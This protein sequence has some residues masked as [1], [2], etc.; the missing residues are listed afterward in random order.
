[1]DIADFCQE[2]S[3]SDGACLFE[4]SDSER[5]TPYTTAELAD[6]FRSSKEFQ[7]IK[8]EQKQP[9]EHT[10]T[11]AQTGEKDTRLTPVKLQREYANSG[12]RATRLNLIR[13]MIIWSRDKRFLVANGVKN[14]IMGISVG[15]VFFQTSSVASI[16]G[17]LFQLNLFIMLGAMTSIPEQVNDRIIFYRHTDANFYGAFSYAIGKAVSLLPQASKS[18]YIGTSWTDT[19]FC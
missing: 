13:N 1:M 5:D 2:I 6:I 18:G 3:T 15:G 11:V 8:E 19:L 14:I 7:R 16:Y 10:W 17:V 4:P 12:L 9:W